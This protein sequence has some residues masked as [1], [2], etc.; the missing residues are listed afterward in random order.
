MVVL[1][2]ISGLGTISGRDHLGGCT[3]LLRIF[4]SDDKE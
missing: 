4:H 2:I 1:G 3:V